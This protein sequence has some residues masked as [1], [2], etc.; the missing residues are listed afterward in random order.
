MAS[1]SVQKEKSLHLIICSFF[2]DILRHSI[3][4]NIWT[5]DTLNLMSLVLFDMDDILKN[6]ISLN[7]LFLTLLLSAHDQD[8]HARFDSAGVSTILSSWFLF[9]MLCMMFFPFSSFNFF[10]VCTNCA[11]GT[12]WTRASL[13]SSKHWRR[14]FQSKVTTWSLW[15]QRG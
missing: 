7:E 14:L 15:I 13:H 5:Y 8:N 1:Y 4:Y 6:F 10:A 3:T 2:L 12:M 11:W 9:F